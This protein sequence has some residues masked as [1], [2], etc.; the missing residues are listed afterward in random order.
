MYSRLFLAIL[1][2]LPAQ[3]QGAGENSSEQQ[4]RS[5]LEKMSVASHNLNYDGVFVYSRG[6]Q[7]DSMRIIHKVDEQGEV[8]RLISLTGASREVVRDNGD[9]ICIYSDNQTVMVDK[10]SANKFLP[11]SLPESITRINAYYNF[12]ILGQDRI[13]GRAT[14][15]VEIMPKDEHRYVYRL[16][17]DRETN[18]MLK[19][20]VVN[21]QEKILETVLF[22]N[23]DLPQEIPSDLMTPMNAVDYS[24]HTNEQQPDLDSQGERQWKAQ[25]L[26]NG[27]SMESSNKKTFSKDQ[28]PM[29]HSVYSD[30][31]ATVSLYIEKIVKGK[32]PMNGYVSQGAVNVYTH[33]KEGF[34]VTVVGELPAKTV[35]KI[36]SSV[37]RTNSNRN[38]LQ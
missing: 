15:I 30:G 31:L 7:L 37:I 33:S 9:L 32:E 5:I 4:A 36:A 22:T 26:P 18:L 14:N 11:S 25:W 28:L 2:T 24:W 13:A 1:I 34:Q 35:H 23:I 38:V 29:E 17:V 27:F 20:A 19:S 10:G 12:R 21:M 16:W 8:E 3:A 6:N